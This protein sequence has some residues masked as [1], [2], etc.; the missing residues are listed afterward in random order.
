MEACGAI[1]KFGGREGEK[2]SKKSNKNKF[3]ELGLAG[4][5]NGRVCLSYLEL[6]SAHIRQNPQNPKINPPHLWCGIAA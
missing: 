5:E 2:G 6:R 4:V 3:A 1:G